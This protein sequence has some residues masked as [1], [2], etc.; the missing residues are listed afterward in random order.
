M[1]YRLI[2]FAEWLRRRISAVAF[3]VAIIACASP[4]G[5]QSVLT[6]HN[7]N[8]RTGQNLNERILTLSNVNVT[9]FGKLFVI[10]VDGKVDAQP[11]YLPGVA[12]PN[13]GT[14]NVLFVA[15]EN[16]SI[17]AFDATNGT[18]LWRR[19]LLKSGETPSDSRNCSQVTPKIG[20]TATPTID[21]LAGP[22]G[23]I[24]VMSIS[25]NSS[26][27]YFQRLHGLNVATGAEQ[28]G[29]PVTIRASFPGTGDNSNNG[30]VIFDPKQYKA[31]PGLLLL[32]GVVYTTW[33]SHCDHRPYTGW[34][35][36]Y[37][38][39][40]LQQVSVLNLAPNGHAAAIWM[41]GG[42]PASDSAGN[43]YIMAG[44]G[45]FETTLNANGFPNKNDFGNAFVKVSTLNGRL[46]V[47]DYFAMFNTLA[48]SS[49]DE[50]LGSGGP[51]VLP[52]LKDS[53]G[54]TWQLVVGAGKDKKIYLLNRNNMGKFNPTFNNIYQ[55]VPTALAGSVFSSPAYFN[56]TLYFGAV[57]DAIRAF[58]FSNARLPSVASS[59]T[60]HVFPYPGATPSISANGT[61]NGIM[62]APENGTVAVLHA[63]DAANLG[64]ELYNSNLA[65]GGRD[66]FGTGNKFITL[67]IANG[68]VYVGTTNGV[69]VF[70]LR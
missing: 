40:T 19:S 55:E 57:G 18:L 44:N 21:P 53:S 62:W 70:G 9:T 66:H 30:S 12:I 67:T 43:V 20:I 46:I 22:N 15:T 10:S 28:F 45:T 36:G 60:S 34:V 47:A 39:A 56:G 23:T 26:S 38:Q 4:A 49:I 6:Y 7:N 24:Y 61:S 17:Y 63:Y 50:D 59:K 2:C 25:K 11:L 65:A 37:N 42:A 5:G 68:R 52:G 48:E 1:Q 41:S 64:R 29:G 69:A 27:G 32:N 51:L 8:A 54:R 31:R 16:D 3:F 35:I 33:G 58:R 14:H 13:K